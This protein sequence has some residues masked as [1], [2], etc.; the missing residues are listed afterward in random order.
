MKNL[1][2]IFFLTAIVPFYLNNS[3][4]AQLIPDQTLGN[5]SSLV[6]STNNL[7]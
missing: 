1:F 7:L 4:S 6:N 5:E 2:Q 3:A